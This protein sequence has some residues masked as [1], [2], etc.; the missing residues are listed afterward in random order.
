VV[1]ED[2]L[3]PRL[4]IESVV[5]ALAG[6]E[7]VAA[8]EDLE[9]LRDAI[10]AT[11]P[12]VVLTDVS[13]PPAY[14]DEGIRIAE[15]LRRTHPDVGVVVLSQ[16]ADPLHA[17]ALFAD[18][19]HGRAYLLKEQIKAPGELERA[20]HE[21]A[22]GGGLLDPRVAEK[23][24]WP[25]YSPA[26]SALAGLTER[27][28]EILGLIAAASSNT[29]I[30]ARLGIGKR[31]VER[32]INAIFAKLG[33]ESGDVSPRVKATLIFLASEGRSPE[34]RPTDAA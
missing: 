3:L 10:E 6:I 15:E 16:D 32:H 1:A 17:K 30:A 23:V 28:R 2:A 19:P 18:G 34:R 29:A 14:T 31:G 24:L 20:I 21:V 7:L 13:M 5:G 27:E 11:T 33:L 12:H 22:R 9:E 26:A 4:G 25:Q 8:C